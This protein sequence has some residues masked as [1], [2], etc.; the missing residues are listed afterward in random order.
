M[1]K[2]IFNGIKKIIPKI[3]ETEMIAL[4]SGTTSIDRE[5]FQGYVNIKKFK[6]SEQTKKFEENKIKELYQKYRNEH[7]FPSNKTDE[8]MNF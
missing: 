7:V 1:Y 8:I 3:S 5:I 6:Q 2:T 4:R